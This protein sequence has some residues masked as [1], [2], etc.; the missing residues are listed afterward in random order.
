MTYENQNGN[1]LSS[2]FSCLKPHKM[3]ERAASSRNVVG[4]VLNSMGSNYGKNHEELINIH[5]AARNKEK[6]VKLYHQLDFLEGF[7]PPIYE[8]TEKELLFLKES[9]SDNFI[10]NNVLKKDLD[11]LIG[12]MCNEKVDSG[13]VIISQGAVG[14]FFYV[15]EEGMV[16]FIV[17]DEKVGH[18][19]PGGSFGELALLYSSPRAATCT[20]KK[21]CS[22]WKVD[23]VTFRSIIHSN[24]SAQAKSIQDT[25]GK[26]PFLNQLNGDQKSKLMDVMTTVSFSPGEKIIKKGDIG[27][28]F[29]II[30]EGDV[31][32]AAI[33]S[34]SG[35]YEDVILGPSAWFG[36]RALLSNMARTAD[37]I[38]ASP[39]VTM[40]I[41]RSDFEVSIGFLRTLLAQEEKNRILHALAIFK[42]LE[43]EEF[44]ALA[45]ELTIKTYFK[46]AV[47]E[48]TG[49]PSSQDLLIIKSGKL[50][51]A[52]DNGVLKHFSNDDYLGLESLRE[53]KGNISTHTVIAEEDTDC[54]CLTKDHIVE[55][56]SDINRIGI[57]TVPQSKD[58]NK[59][60]IEFDELQKMR[61]LGIGT[62]GTVWLV[63]HKKNNEVNSY[64]LKIMSKRKLV[65][66]KQV[67]SVI[68]EKE[69]MFSVNHPFII[70]ILQAYQD[71][72]NVFFLTELMQ[73][74]ELW[75][76]LHTSTRNG[77]DIKYAMFYAACTLLALAHL[78]RRHICYRDLK[79]ENILIDTQGYCKLI[80]VGFAKI[81][82]NKTYTFCGT[83]EYIAPEIILSKGHDKGVDYWALGVLIYEMM[84]GQSAF[85]SSN[86]DQTALFRRIVKA[87]VTFPP[88][89]ISSSGKKL[90]SEL[91]VYNQFERLGNRAGGAKSIC[92][93]EF[94][95]SINFFKLARKQL[96]AP[97]IPKIKNPFDSSNFDE[98]TPVKENDENLRKLTEEEEDLFKHFN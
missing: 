21:N 33:G 67:K 11:M 72:T 25:L 71:E 73:G 40:C 78:H 66:C 86:M 20:A 83:P 16:D 97:W 91:L 13:S 81:V 95:Y 79:P 36:E 92:Q 12:A 24:A 1:C 82:T 7:T 39:C 76:L 61:I 59:I 6:R 44:D 42:L 54:Y 52:Y 60:Q 18:C 46:G 96:K 8:K 69:V 30:S 89:K 47:L 15:V 80:D 85:S 32:V 43:E 70:K 90:I 53:E 58:E 37:V 49:Q 17:N 74:G 94:F 3:L 31:R 88:K 34:G 68:R 5:T 77:V 26:V 4:S 51:V 84:F 56:V 14:D 29:Y 65:D 9:L 22:L 75:S 19:S 63:K 27:E 10:F 38:A 23:Q 41:S 64:A 45:D 50:M 62:F 93:H 98:F 57:C 48:E 28:V 35:Q 87:N 2:C 55:I